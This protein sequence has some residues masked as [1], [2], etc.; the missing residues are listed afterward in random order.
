ED[1]TV[2]IERIRIHEIGVNYF[3][4]LDIESGFL[5]RFAHRCFSRPLERFNRTAG[6]IPCASYWFV[7]ALHQQHLPVII[8]DSRLNADI[9]RDIPEIF[10]ESVMSFF[11]GDI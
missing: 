6:N 11:Y 4:G 2:W 9:R 1:V 7:G 10:S 8:E 5:T 3:D